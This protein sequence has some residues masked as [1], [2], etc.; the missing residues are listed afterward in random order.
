MQTSSGPLVPS[1]VPEE[2]FDD[3]RE[4]VLFYIR[5]D[6]SGLMDPRSRDFSSPLRIVRGD[7]ARK[8]EPG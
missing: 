7:A 1:T 6:R 5:D 2:P 8:D 3:S 4:T